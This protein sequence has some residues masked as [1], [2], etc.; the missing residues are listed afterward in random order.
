MSYNRKARY[1]GQGPNGG[2]EAKFEYVVQPGDYSA[3]L[4]YVATDSMDLNSGQ[5]T[6][7]RMSTTPTTDADLTLPD[8]TSV[9]GTLAAAG[10]VIAINGDV[11]RDANDSFIPR[12]INVVLCAVDWLLRRSLSRVVL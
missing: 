12:V 5:A 3:N 8:P 2:H 10:Q 11:R 6:I 7:K 1:V 4:R 9:A